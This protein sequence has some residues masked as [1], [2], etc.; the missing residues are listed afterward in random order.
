MHVLNAAESSEYFDSAKD[1]REDSAV[2][3]IHWAW[4]EHSSTLARR[5]HLEPAAPLDMLV[6]YQ[7]AAAAF[8]EWGGGTPRHEQLA[9]GGR[10]INR[11]QAEQ[12][13]NSIPDATTAALATR[14]ANQVIAFSSNA[15]GEQD[16]SYFV[17]LFLCWF[18]G[19]LCG[20][21]TA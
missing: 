6:L 15:A 4:L 20:W 12:R 2:R 3:V 7:A 8:R 13:L 16:L 5:E 1:A 18:F 17:E 9:H 14:F 19:L 11:E 10:I 21:K